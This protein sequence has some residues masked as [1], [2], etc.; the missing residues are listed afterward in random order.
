VPEDDKHISITRYL[1]A[2][3]SVVFEAWTRPELMAQ[4]FFP[5]EEW[6]ASITQELKVG[7]QYEIAMR[8]GGGGKHRQFG[9]YREIVPESRLV[10]TWS[11]PEL[12]VVDSVVTVTL[13]DHGDRTELQLTHELPPDPKIRKGHEDGW[14]GCLGNLDKLLQTELKGI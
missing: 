4:W 10:F 1:K 5:G 11:C 6:T 8:D 3:P 12:A 2:P 14:I 9:V 7:G 13:V